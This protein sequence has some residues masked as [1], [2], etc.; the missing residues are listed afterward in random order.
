MIKSARGCLLHKNQQRAASQ[1]DEL[2]PNGKRRRART[3]GLFPQGRD[4][5]LVLVQ[6]DGPAVLFVVV[7]HITE[8]VI[9]EVADCEKDEE[10]V[11]S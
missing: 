11:S 1:R 7:L 3:F 2:N 9:V 10:K 6:R 4:R 8:W 5:R